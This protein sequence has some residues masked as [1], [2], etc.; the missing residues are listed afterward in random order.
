[1][2]IKVSVQAKDKTKTFSKNNVISKNTKEK[3]SLNSSTKSKLSLKKRRSEN[4]KKDEFLSFNKKLNLLEVRYRELEKLIIK[5]KSTT[6]IVRNIL[7]AGFVTF[8]TYFI[9]R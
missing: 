4:I 2:V 1:M 9:Q 8:L 7:L 5:L 3:E 6:K